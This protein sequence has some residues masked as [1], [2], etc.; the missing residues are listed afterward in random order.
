MTGFGSAETDGFK[1]EIKSLNQ[2]HMD[3]SVKMP[4]FLSENEIPVRNIVK[5][6]FS[7]GKFD[8]F[9]ALTDKRK[10]KISVDKE[11]AKSMYEAFSSLQ[12]EL[13]LPGSIGM[14]MLSGYRD[15]LISEEPQYDTAALYEAVKQAVFKLREARKNEGEALHKEMLCL[16]KKLEDA[17]SE[18]EGFAA[19]AASDYRENLSKKISEIASNIAIDE[20]RLA[21][22]IALIAQKAD[23]TEEM[24]RLKSHFRQFDSFLTQG[25]VIGRR[26]DF[27][28]QEM[29]REV[30]TIASKSDDIRIINLTISMKTEMEKLREQAQN[31]E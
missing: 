31:I 10:P 26:L 22:E 13:S 12:R 19:G 30:N 18:I 15:I 21:Q 28:L 6:N 4:S 17:N 16:L 9:V 8:V 27:L 11:L 1:V 23:I 20:T 3:I 29:N 25:G 7:R 24:A 2:R 5:K 14:D